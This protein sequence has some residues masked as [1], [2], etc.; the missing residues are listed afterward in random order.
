MFEDMAVKTT[1]G[2]TPGSVYIVAFE[3]DGLRVSV[4]PFVHHHP[5]ILALALRV[6]VETMAPDG[7]VGL[8]ASQFNLPFQVKGGHA[9]TVLAVPIMAPPFGPKEANEIVFS[10]SLINLLLDDLAAH[11]TKNKKMKQVTAKEVLYEVLAN[12]VSDQLPTDTICEVEHKVYYDDM[13]PLLDQIKTALNLKAEAK[14]K[15]TAK[16]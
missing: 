6:R 5:L 10:K 11:I 12:Q 1:P 2:T 13:T 14:K 9:S 16:E 4:R 7:A 3:G 15:P 8:A